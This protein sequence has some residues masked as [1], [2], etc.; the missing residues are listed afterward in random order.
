MTYRTLIT[1]VP[2]LQKL[3]SQNAPIRVAYRLSKIVRRV[4]EELDFFKTRKAELEASH[5]Y[6]V[7]P[8]EYDRLLDFEIDWEE[9]RVEIPLDANLELSCADVDALEPF[10]SLKED[11]SN[12]EN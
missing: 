9:P 3:V 12:A 7:P 5:E 11:E 4:N 10:I 8:D 1:A 6:A 2:A